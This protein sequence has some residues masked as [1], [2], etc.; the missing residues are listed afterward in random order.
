MA[1]SGS[2][3]DMLDALAKHVQRFADSNWDYSPTTV[4]SGLEKIHA[5][6]SGLK[7]CFIAGFNATHSSSNIVCPVTGA[8][9][10]PDAKTGYA[11]TLHLG[12]TRVWNVDGSI[13]EERWQKFVLF[14]TEGQG[15]EADKI[16][17]FSKLNAYLAFCYEND[18]QEQSTGRN[19]NALFSSKSVQGTAATKAWEEVFDRL[20]E[21]WLPV[22]GKTNVWEP[23]IT[24][25]LVR[26]FF[27]DSK[28]AFQRAENKLLPVPKPTAN[29][30]PQF[31]N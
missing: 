24:L 27:E 12:T 17:V 20:A 3:A 21:G 29:V 23:Y 25:T 2:T 16:V 31:A 1:L 8:R 11:K 4:S 14:V 7:G 6:Q 5:H 13:N 9:F 18:L 26:E 30:A 19:T 28:A 22:A 10:L 15:P